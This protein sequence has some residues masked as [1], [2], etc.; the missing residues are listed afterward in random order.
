MPLSRLARKI[1]AM[2][3]F[4]IRP[5][6]PCSPAPPR[7]TAVRTGKSA[8]VP[9]DACA[10]DTRETRMMPPR[11][12]SAPA[13]TKTTTRMRSTAMPGPKGG[14][15]VVAG[16]VD[17]RPEARPVEDE[18]ADRVADEQDDHRDRDRADV[19]PR[20]PV[21]GVERL[22]VDGGPAGEHDPR[23]R[24]RCSACPVSPPR[25]GYGATVTRKPL[26]TPTTRPTAT[27]AVMAAAE[28]PPVGEDRRR[29]RRRPAPMTE[30]NEMSSSPSRMTKVAPIAGMP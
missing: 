4:S 23:S 5:R 21:D 1:E 28:L 9:N 16:Q 6:P 3:V 19:A 30:P 2:S 7:M 24:A 20:E 11:P 29:R 10:C 26:I 17:V 13:M 18:P 14:L 15:A 8:S 27:A 22:T 12:A 25:T